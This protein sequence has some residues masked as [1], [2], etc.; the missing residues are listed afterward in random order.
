MLVWFVIVVVVIFLIISNYFRQ[1]R[2]ADEKTLRT[3]SEWSIMANSRNA[4]YRERMSYSLVV[5]AGNILENMGVFSLKSLRM[6]MRDVP[7]ISK[8]NFVLLIL[9]TAADL[10]PES[11]M[12]E[13]SYTK[14]QARQHL[15][16]CIELIVKNGGPRALAR[17]AIEARNEVVF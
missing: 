5:Q 3:I 15:A 16:I 13:A 12:L 6:L 7:G 14:N 10:H 9:L 4:K 8:A 17:I 1:H 2:E 11:D